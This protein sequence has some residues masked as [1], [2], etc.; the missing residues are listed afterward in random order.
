MQ[1][2]TVSHRGYDEEPWRAARKRPLDFFNRR[3]ILTRNRADTKEGRMTMEDLW[4]RWIVS[5]SA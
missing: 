1:R 5:G 4:A 2:E 3:L